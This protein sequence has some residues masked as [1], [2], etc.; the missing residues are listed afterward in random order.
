MRLV[1]NLQA[2]NL[3]L[4][5]TPPLCSACSDQNATEAMAANRQTLSST[6]Q[7]GGAASAP[8][9][10]STSA[11]PV[12]WELGCEAPSSFV[13]VEF[14]DG[15]VLARSNLGGQ[16]G[17]CSALDLCDEVQSS[18]T[19]HEILIR[20]VGV[21]EIASQY[22]EGRRTLQEPIDL[23]ITNTT[24]YH[25]WNTNV[26]GITRRS[27]E[28]YASFGVINLLGPRLPSQSGYSWNSEF[29]FVELKFEFL[30]RT[31]SA[32]SAAVTHTPI[33][34]RRTFLTFYDFD[35]GPSS[36]EAI[37][38]EPTVAA[39]LIPSPSELERFPTWADFA[40]EQKIAA[41]F[42]T[43][44]SRTRLE[45]W[46]SLVTAATRRG[47]GGDNPLDSYRL[48]AVQTNRSLMVRLENTSE[49]RVRF[50]IGSCC[51]TG[52]NFLIGGYS[53]IGRPLCEESP[54]MPP[55]TPPAP[56]VPAVKKL[57]STSSPA[58]GRI[59]TVSRGASI[60]RS[61]VTASAAISADT[62]GQIPPATTPVQREHR[63]AGER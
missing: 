17:R 5:R 10:G 41:F 11:A 43:L 49:F 59:G 24:E 18:T 60:R 9:R 55:S 20:D 29:T 42:P 13:R 53:F 7:M 47:V 57:R 61:R 22:N 62:P 4:H 37:Q 51:T 48:T 50:A 45:A 19:P 26:N 6:T 31:A 39:E 38:V 30:T 28:R 63:R 36:A 35:S 15:A 3:S 32:W 44:V 27:Q 52:R 25:G 23:R 8:S 56:P 58:H 21:N 2:L 14:F 46:A 1:S 54:V 12:D 33:T 40:G 16:G 34:L